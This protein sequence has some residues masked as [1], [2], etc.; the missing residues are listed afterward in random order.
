MKSPAAISHQRL[1]KVCLA[2][3]L[4]LGLLGAGSQAQAWTLKDAAKPYA[5]TTIHILDEITPLQETLKKLVPQFEAESGIKVDYELLNHFEVINKGQ[6]DLLSKRA[7]YDAVM[8]HSVQIGQMLAAGVLEP[9]DPF[10]GNASLT[11][12]GL[13][14]KD[15]LNPANDTTTKFGGKSYGFLTWNY[16]MIY[17]ARA[18]LLNDPGE[19]VAF[20]AKY[21]YELAPAKTYKQFLDI[22]E[23]FTRKAGEKLAGQTL[24]SDFYGI[25][26]EG[27]PGGATLVS[28]WQTQF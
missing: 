8:L 17:W 11:D 15:I 23:F 26:H 24:K 22:G 18:D 12:P 13:D 14:M 3:G 9:I 25:L 10:L 16:N 19:K 21:G 1:N 4:T 2:I 6:A 28:V 27:I 20:K 5:G 7:A